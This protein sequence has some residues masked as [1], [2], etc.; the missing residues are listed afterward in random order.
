MGRTAA[1]RRGAYRI[2]QNC[3]R[4]AL[5]IDPGL[6]QIG[7]TQFPRDV[8]EIHALL[9]E[10]GFAVRLG[11]PFTKPAPASTSISIRSSIASARCRRAD[12]CVAGLVTGGR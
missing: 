4:V 3:I 2:R 12:V 5:A 9:F 7:M 8:E 1:P 11:E 10:Q 6:Q